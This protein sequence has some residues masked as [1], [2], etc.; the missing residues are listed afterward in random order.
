MDL[1]DGHCLPGINLPRSSKSGRM[2][3]SARSVSLSILQ[4]ESSLSH[5]HTVMHQTFGQ[6]LDHDMDRTAI[7]MLSKDEEGMLSLR[8]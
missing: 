4:G 8:N 7:T 1:T 2:L 5:V 6:F 3:H